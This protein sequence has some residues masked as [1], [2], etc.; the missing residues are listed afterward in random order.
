ME[1]IQ[2]APTPKDQTQLRSF[3]GLLHYYTK[4][5]PNLTSVLYP[6]N[7]LLQKDVPWKWTGDC[8]RA[9][10]GAKEML[11]SAPLLAHSA[12]CYSL[13]GMPHPMDWGSDLTSI[14]MAQSIQLRLPHG[15]LP[16]ASEIMLS[17]IRRL[18][19]FSVWNSEIP[20]VFIWLNVHAVY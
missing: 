16:G 20:P 17:W 3:L 18:G 6:L 19:F 12:C 14:L 8:Q 1:A 9:F 10:E 4:S 7:R 11:T 2:L 15:L 13:R 5:M